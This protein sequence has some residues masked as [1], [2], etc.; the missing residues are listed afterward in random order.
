MIDRLFQRFSYIW[1]AKW[2]KQ[3]D[4]DPEGLARE[5]GEALAGKSPQALQKALAAARQNSIWPPS[6]AEFLSYCDSAEPIPAPA[7]NQG[8]AIAGCPAA[9]TM[10]AATHG[11]R[12]VC[13]RHF[14]EGKG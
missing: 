7:A 3:F 8:C 11:S 9:G 2:N 5:W 10:C 1:A 4:A 14:Q 13:N 6:I 12:W